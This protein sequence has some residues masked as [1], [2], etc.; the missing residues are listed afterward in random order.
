MLTQSV[1]QILARE[2]WHVQVSGPVSLLSVLYTS[3]SAPCRQGIPR[4]DSV[5]E[6]VPAVQLA[7]RARETLLLKRELVTL[8]SGVTDS[9]PCHVTRNP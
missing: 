6:L 9:V 1:S 2:V 8:V 4:V 5:R 3:L 7:A